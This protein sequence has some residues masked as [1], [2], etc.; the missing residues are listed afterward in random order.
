MQ[1][2]GKKTESASAEDVGGKN[3]KP[4]EGVRLAEGIK[5]ELARVVELP[6]ELDHDLEMAYP[7]LNNLRGF[8]VG[9]V[10]VLLQ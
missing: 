5:A 2:L 7:L 6:G 3:L 8:F 10:T 4:E 1:R 9:T